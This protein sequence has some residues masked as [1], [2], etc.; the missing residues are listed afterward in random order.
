MLQLTFINKTG[1]KQK[2]ILLMAEAF[3]ILAGS[4]ALCQTEEINHLQQIGFSLSIVA[5]NEMRLSGECP[6]LLF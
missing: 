2:M 1:F 4:E 3:L 6:T 5:E